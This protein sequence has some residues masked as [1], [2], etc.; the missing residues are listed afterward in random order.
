MTNAVMRDDG[1]ASAND[2]S[3]TSTRRVPLRRKAAAAYIRDTHGQ[4]CAAKTL[5]KLASVGGGPAF[6]K[7][8]K[9]PLY[10]PDD[11][12]IWALARLSRKV[13]RAAET[14]A[15]GKRQRK[16]PEPMTAP[17]AA[18]DG[19]HTTPP[20]RPRKAASTTEAIAK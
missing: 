2:R 9:Y 19:A 6:R 20:P 15:S 17:V 16:R 3:R 7:A 4:P 8:G 18:K 5:A 12:D 10:E 13:F 14:K 1:V 11:L